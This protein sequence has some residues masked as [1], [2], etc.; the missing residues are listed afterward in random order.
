MLNSCS[1]YLKGQLGGVAGR[2]LKA[3]DS[4]GVKSRLA[5]DSSF[6]RESR[7]RLWAMKIYLSAQLGLRKRATIRVIKG[8]HW[9]L[10]SSGA[11]LDFLAKVFRI[12][13]HSVRTGYRKNGPKRTVK[14]NFHIF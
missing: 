11:T 4:V 1:T 3:G 9:P 8:P 10:F 7:R 12:P 14:K 13:L 6:L 5:A 2:A